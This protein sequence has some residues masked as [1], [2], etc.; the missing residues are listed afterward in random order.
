M[1]CFSSEADVKAILVATAEANDAAPEVITQKRI[2]GKGTGAR[3]VTFVVRVAAENE[4]LVNALTKLT[5]TH[6]QKLWFE[7]SE[8]NL[9]AGQNDID[10][11]YVS[12]NILPNLS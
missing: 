3:V 5:I 12:A 1:E 8:I 4:T 10:Y 6:N 11:L 2:G 7:G 9:Q